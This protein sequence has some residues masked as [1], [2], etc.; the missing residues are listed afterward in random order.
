MRPISR[1]TLGGINAMNQLG[2]QQQQ[3]AQRALD[4]YWQ[5]LA[6][7]RIAAQD[8]Q[9]RHEHNRTC[10]ST[11]RTTV[12]TRPSRPTGVP[13]CWVALGLATKAGCLVRPQGQDRY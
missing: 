5:Q 2:T 11:S 12:G 1:A 8:C 6:Q 9:S 3:T 10:K 13:F 4:Y 7:L